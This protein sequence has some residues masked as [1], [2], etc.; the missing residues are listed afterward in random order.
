M[1]RASTIPEHREPQVKIKARGDKLPLLVM[2]HV[3][4][5]VIGEQSIKEEKAGP[6]S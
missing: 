6:Q 5:N 4:N 3:Y 1:L 2:G